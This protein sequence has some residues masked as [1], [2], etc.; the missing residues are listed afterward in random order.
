MN[1]HIHLL[2][3]KGG[4]S[5][6]VFRLFLFFFGVLLYFYPYCGR[7]RDSFLYS[8]L[9]DVRPSQVNATTCR[10]RYSLLCLLTRHN[11]KD[12]RGSSSLR[13]L[14]DLVV[15]R[16]A[17]QN[18]SRLLAVFP[19]HPIHNLPQTTMIGE[20]RPRVPLRSAL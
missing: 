20:S 1:M 4:S 12:Q 10:A 15:S 5:F 8:L 11:Q 13:H 6:Q 7:G 18:P 2:V 16:V 3:R 17:L 14:S 19:G 9:I